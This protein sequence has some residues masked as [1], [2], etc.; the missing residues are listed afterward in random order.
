MTLKRFNLHA[1]LKERYLDI[2][3]RATGMAA[4]SQLFPL[5]FGV[6]NAEDS[7]SWLWF[8]HQLHE[9][10]SQSASSH[11]E[12]PESLIFPSDLQKGLIDGVASVSPHCPHAYCLRRLEDNMHKNFKNPELKLLLWKA[13]RAPTASM[14]NEVINQMRSIYSHCVEWLE[15]TTSKEHWAEGFFPGR[16][17]DHLTSNIAESLNSWILEAHFKPIFN[18]PEHIRLQMMTWYSEWMEK[19]IRETGNVVST[20]A[21][22]IQSSVRKFARFY[23]LK[24]STNEIW[25][26]YSSKRDPDNQSL[27]YLYLC[28]CSK[29][30]SYIID[31]STKSCDCQHW[32]TSGIP[33]AHALAAILYRKL[34]PFDFVE[35]CYKTE[36]YRS[37]Y[38]TPISPIPDRS[39]W[40]PSDSDIDDDEYVTI[41]IHPPATS[42]APGR[43]KTLRHRSKKENEEESTRVLTCNGCDETGQNCRACTKP[44]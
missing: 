40:M 9:A 22:T 21:H 7:S 25:E 14:F 28:S 8:L 2:L 30:R 12:K 23:T 38:S 5:A 34:D 24:R 26:V 4:K 41:V 3:L 32:Q 1:H 42:R 44:I 43:P 13:A 15:S 11:L 19:R 6:V 18:M 35:K 27:K 31:L 29:G 20:V 16:C 39:I 10:I 36:A 17:Y 33:S 37:T